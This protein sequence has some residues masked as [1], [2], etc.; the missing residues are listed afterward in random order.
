MPDLVSGSVVRVV[1]PVE[2]VVRVIPVAGPQG[3]PG[4][5]LASG[6]AGAN[7]SVWTVIQAGVVPSVQNGQT[8]G[9][10]T[11]G[12]ATSS[13]TA[14]Q[15]VTWAEHGRITDPSWTW[16]PG[17]DIYLSPTSTLTQ[18]LPTTGWVQV[19]ARA[20]SPTVAWVLIQTPYKLA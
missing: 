11:I 13:A 17:A 4:G 18:T 14:G 3:P 10:K 2:Q 5:S 15:P 19:V 9:P 6:T 20:I 1:P 12:V 16:A 8:G 7:I